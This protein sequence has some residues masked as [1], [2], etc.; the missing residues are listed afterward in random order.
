MRRLV[1]IISILS[2]GLGAYT[3]VPSDFAFSGEKEDSMSTLSIRPVHKPKE[4]LRKIMK[5][6][7]S[8]LKQKHGARKYKVEATFW[9]DMFPSFFAS[10]TLPVEGDNGL[11]ILGAP[12]EL[13]RL[14]EDVEDFHYEGQDISGGDSISLKKELLRSIAFSP[15]HA[16]NYYSNGDHARSPFVRYEET[17]RWFKIDVY[18]IWYGSERSMYRVDMVKKKD[19]RLF[20]FGDSFFW[21]YDY[22][23]SAL[24]DCHTLRII[25]IKGTMQSDEEKGNPIYYYKNYQIEYD[26][27]GDAPVLNNISFVR[28]RSHTEKKCTVRRISQ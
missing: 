26:E 24:F 15:T 9:V 22:T 5:R 16:S 10:C 6:L 11:E 14:V 23:V 8:D 28:K 3:Q 7:H 4:M 21:R 25:Q 27:D 1:F 20:R 12:F 18:E 17:T 2:W 19:R 13:K